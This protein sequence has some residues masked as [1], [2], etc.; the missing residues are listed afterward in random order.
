MM[1]TKFLH[2]NSF[3]TAIAF[4]ECQVYKAAVL[5]SLSMGVPNHEIPV[6]VTFSRSHFFLSD[7]TT[8]YSVSAI[9]D[10]DS[11]RFAY[12][13]CNWS[14]GSFF[15]VTEFYPTRRKLRPSEPAVLG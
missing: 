7:L 8:D 5:T 11:N 14:S 2:Q 6:F 4:M 12:S 13:Q 1:H 9:T 3:S 15:S 10:C